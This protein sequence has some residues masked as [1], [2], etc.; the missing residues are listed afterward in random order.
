LILY[1][2]FQKAGPLAFALGRNVSGE[3]VFQNISKMPHLLVAGA[4]GSGKS[5]SIHSIIISLLYKNSPEMLKFIMVDPNGWDGDGDDP[6]AE[7]VIKGGCGID[8]DYL[9]KFEV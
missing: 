3:P 1:P 9:W 5:I 6:W 7:E 8:S 2:E 4:T